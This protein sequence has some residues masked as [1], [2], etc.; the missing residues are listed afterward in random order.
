MRSA[1]HY[2][3]VLGCADGDYESAAELINSAKRIVIKA[4]GGAVGAK[5]ELAADC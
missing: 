3:S 1:G 5:E 4:G 2:Q